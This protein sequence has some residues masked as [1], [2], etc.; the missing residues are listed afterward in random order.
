MLDI[1]PNNKL[2]TVYADL[3]D[4]RSLPANKYDCIV[5]TQTLQFIPVYGS[6][7]NNLRKML[8]RNGVLLATFSAA[9]KIDNGFRPISDDLWR[10]TPASGNLIF[11]EYFSKKKL[12]IKAYGNILATVAFLYGIS[13]EELTHEELDY[14][15]PL[16]PLLG[17][18]RAQK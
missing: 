2:A 3:T 17:C 15:D 12:T 4:S 8:K 18:V 14:H 7:L 1:D 10:F 13:T 16:F 11:S 6:V 5:L 9:S